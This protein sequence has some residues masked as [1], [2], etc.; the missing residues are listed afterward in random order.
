[1][2]TVVPGVVALLD[3]VTT[4]TPAEAPVVDFKTVTLAPAGTTTV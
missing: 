3:P 4:T 2:V 1:V